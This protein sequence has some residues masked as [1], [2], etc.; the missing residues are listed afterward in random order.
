M[1]HLFAACRRTVCCDERVSQPTRLMWKRLEVSEVR[2]RLSLLTI[3]F[4][5]R[6]P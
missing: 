3:V 2:A 5:A 1:P 6:R 4:G